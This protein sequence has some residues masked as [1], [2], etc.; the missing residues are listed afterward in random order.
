M[1]TLK[2]HMIVLKGVDCA[3]VDRYP[4]LIGFAHNRILGLDDLRLYSK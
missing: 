1:G 2:P 3:T 4:G